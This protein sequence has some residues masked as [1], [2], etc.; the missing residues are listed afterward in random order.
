M[1]TYDVEIPG[2]GTF[3]L[4]A[5]Q[6]MS[7]AEIQQAAS[8][9]DSGGSEQPPAA[10]PRTFGE[11]WGQVAPDAGVAGQFAGI[12]GRRVGEAVDAAL[13][14]PS[15]I[16]GIV[17]GGREG[18][19]TGRGYSALRTLQGIASPIST[20]LAPLEAGTEEAVTGLTGSQQW[21]RFAGDVSGGVAT[22]GMGMLA[23]AGK[24]GETGLALAKAIGAGTGHKSFD[25]LIMRDPQ[26]AFVAEAP[27]SPA[28]SELER[29]ARGSASMAD[30]TAE[31][32]RPKPTISDIAM[33][34]KNPTLAE[35]GL[36]QMAAE[37]DDWYK[38]AKAN[39]IVSE[40]PPE[41]RVETGPLAFVKPYFKDWTFLHSLGTMATQAAA[42]GKD[43]ADMALDIQRTAANIARAV[44]NRRARTV[45]A[46]VGVGDADVSRAV[47]LQGVKNFDELMA[48]PENQVSSAVKNVIQFLHDKVEVDRNIGIARRR[49]ELRDRFAKLVQ[50]KMPN[51]T[52]AEMGTEV[53]RLV[54]QAVPDDFAYGE[55]IRSIM[56]G[57]FEIK[58]KDGTI[59][60]SAHNMLDAK[61]KI[62]EM[63]QKG[64]DPANID[65]KP[66]ANFDS[67]LLRLFKGRV[68]KN[69]TSMAD[70]LSLSREE[71]EAAAKGQFF[72]QKPGVQNAFDYLAGLRERVPGKTNGQ[73]TRDLIDVLSAQDRA[74]ERWLQ[75]GELRAAS[76]PVMKDIASRYPKLAEKLNDN[77][78]LLWGHRMPGSVSV[79][80][81]VASTPILRDIIAPQILEKTVGTIKAGMVLGMLKWSPRFHAVNFTQIPATLWPIADA[82]EILEAMKLRGSEE[83]ARILAKHG[84]IDT[85]K[86]E[87]ASKGLG[88]S[89]KFNQETAFLTMYNRARKFG[90]TDQQAADYGLLRG[91]V[92]SQFMGLTTD[93]PIAFR[94]ID[95]TGLFTMFQ[96]FPIKQAEML[97]DIMKYKDFP[98]AAKWLG[99]QLVTGGFKAATMG[100]V[101]FLSYKV[102]KDLEERYG[103]HVADMFNVGLPGLAGIDLSGSVQLFN[104]PFGETWGERVGNFA[105]GPFVSMVQSVMGAALAGNS[106]EPNGFYRA[107][108]SLAEKVPA[109]KIVKLLPDLIEGTQYDFKDPQGR[110]RYR[111]DWY[112]LFKSLAGFKNSA[113]TMGIQDPN[114]PDTMRPGKYDTFID[115]MMDL[116]RR[117]DDVLDYVASRYG[118]AQA[119]GVSL[120]KDMMDLIKNEVDNWNNLWP[121]MPIDSKAIENRAAARRDAVIQGVVQRTMKSAPTA[122]KNSPIFAPPQRTSEEIP[123]PPG[124]PFEFF[125]GG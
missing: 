119:A 123:P 102:Y 45:N 11:Q 31:V 78:Q 111:G 26:L 108:S 46:L 17:T 6:E 39:N 58:A 107:L 18:G 9:F 84:V 68:S 103:K 14:L 3:T 77:L 71:I 104:P 32:A 16:A 10:A 15:S 92:Y 99:T 113:G 121:E 29:M 25:E 110:L 67:D 114:A 117:R 48:A 122:I 124:L 50:D 65:V 79:D 94:R 44:A 20:I 19:W 40:M 120:S 101:G 53:E 70:A 87:G 43:A 89:E 75:V 57:N 86:V 93:Q 2:K 22:I 34:M 56:P 90:L 118:Q 30:L 35:A 83:G 59:L 66:T 1:P 116:K 109:F 36:N 4:N 63:A 8:E 28:S 88:I 52:T 24:L 81:L 73:Y 69:F 38:A 33:G 100:N 13:N 37:A 60:F 64:L 23:N 85:S 49:D 97:I 112:D 105:K 106:P 12:T 91:Q 27:P 55:G 42:F 61:M 95:P 51:A 76:R 7:D 80:N 72:L 21:G 74:M 5:E 62:Y 96:R 54:K 98:A 41:P 115:A 125:G 47:V 82:G